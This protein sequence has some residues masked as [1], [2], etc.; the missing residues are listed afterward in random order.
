[1]KER[2]ILFNGKSV[3]GILE[4]RKTQT[5]RVVK[6]RG[7]DDNVA[8]FLHYMAQAVDM[9]CPYGQPG[10]R[11]WVRETWAHDDMDCKD[12]HCGNIDHIWYRASEVPIVAESFSG[13]AAWRPS[14]FM[15]RWA[16]R[17][18]LEITS[19]RAE[20]VQEISA[21]DAIAEGYPA[22]LKYGDPVVG[23]IPTLLESL[24]PVEHYRRA[25]DSIN[26]KRGFGWDVNPWV[27]VVEFERVLP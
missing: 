9:K 5:R 8:Q 26:A 11:L 2:P 25:W 17:I 23:G 4:K 10:D 7:V 27:W 12:A 21:E 24:S 18:T 19:I 20:R 14:I 6:P 15:P 22:Y 3:R 16:S 13:S 1:M